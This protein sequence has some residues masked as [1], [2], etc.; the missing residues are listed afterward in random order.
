MINLF[1]T[2]S[3]LLLATICFYSGLT[4]A[5]PKYGAVGELYKGTCAACHGEALQGTSLGSVLVNTELKKGD[6]LEDI[7]LS[8]S[9]GNPEAGMPAWGSILKDE[10]LHSLAIFV[11]EQ[12]AG[13]DYD[14]YNMRE[15]ASIPQ[16]VQ[17]AKQHDFILTTLVD[18]LDP[19]P[20]SIEP[21]SDGRMLLVEKKRG[22]SIISEKG[23]QS[24]L[25]TGTPK[26]YDDSKLPDG[27]RALDRG[28]GWMQDVV[29]H[30]DYASNG[31][32]Y[33]YY[34]DRCNDCN[35]ISREKKL[36][37]G[38]TKIVRGRILN[39]E[40]IDQQTIWS[41]GYEN[42]TTN[43]DL[44]IG[45]R[46]ALDDKGYVYF[47]IGAMNGFYDADIQDLSR[48]WGKIHRVHDDGRTPVDN[49]FVGVADAVQSVWTVGHRAPQG[50]E[51][52]VQTATLWGSEHGPRGGDE[53]NLL[54]SGRNYGWPLTSRGVDYDGSSVE[55]KVDIKFNIE[56]IEQPVVDLTP[57]P[58]ISS[59]VVYH[60]DQFPEWD[61]DIIAGSLKAGTLYHF[62]I[63]DNKFV[64]KE[65]LIQGIGRIRDV[66]VDAQGRILLLSENAAGSKIVR[67]SPAK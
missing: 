7:K 24:E 4:T 52:D 58:A 56:D 62:V 54:L 55:G 47:S 42:Y 5:Q 19:L 45:G 20:Y 27:L 8:I 38:M 34:G 32:I 40:W 59:F 23:E 44:A 36:P 35:A 14:S 33:I 50:L 51:Y 60:G 48:P 29:V 66:E 65:I 31:W 39:G 30:P 21:L 25:I 22:L 12:R 17:Q 49:P 3:V 18:D 37:V 28:K 1:R 53:V 10:Q 15:Q 57:S 2:P 13:F 41:T 61:G 46:M 9:E 63:K 67:M 64:E 6:S 43:T 16:G 26:V 11:L